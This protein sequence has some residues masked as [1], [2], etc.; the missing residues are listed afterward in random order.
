MIW[1][2]AAYELNLPSFAALTNRYHPH[3]HILHSATV[4]Q[5]DNQMNMYVWLQ[6]CEENLTACA[7]LPAVTMLEQRVWMQLQEGCYQPQDKGD[8]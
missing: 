6:T 8:K 1:I 4:T 2:S 3:S 5:S 7:A